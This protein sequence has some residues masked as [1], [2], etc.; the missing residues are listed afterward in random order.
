MTAI[1]RSGQ[2]AAGVLLALTAAGAAQAEP[3][4]GPSLN[5]ITVTATRVAEP[6]DQ[7][8]EPILVINRAEL[9]DSLAIDVG[10]V[11]RYHAGLD[12]GQTGG[13]GQ[14]LSL[15]IRGTN[16]DQS[17]VM[18]DGVRINAGT[19]ALAPLMNLSP[20]LFDRI[21]IVKG[22]RSAIYGT[23]AIGGVVNLLTRTGGVA[24]A[25]AMLDY[26]RYGT[27][28]FAVDGNYTVGGTSMQGALTGQQTS[29]FP[30]YAADTLD[31]GYKNLSGTAAITTHLGDFE[32]GARYFQATG[33]TDYANAV[34]NT[35]FTAFQSFTPLSEHFSNSLYALHASGDLTDFWHTLV[36][37]SR[38]VDDLRQEQDDPYALGSMGDFDYT[39]R[40]TIDLQNDVKITGARLNQTLTFGTIVYDEQTNSLIYGTGY[41][42]DTHAQTYYLQDQLE[43]GE[44][45]LL[46][47]T[48]VAH[49]PG[50]GD[51]TTW[52]AEYGY[53][54]TTD[55]LLTML[56]GTAFRAPSATDRFGFA[57]TPNLLPESSHNFEIGMK[58]RIASHQEI[59]FAA[60]QDTIDDLIVFVPNPLNIIYGGENQNVDRARIRGIEASWAL[61]ADLWSVLA[62]A[63]LQDP[64]N[65]ADN[66][67]LL[68]RTKH[69]FTLNGT[70]KIGRGEL[71][72]DLLLSGPRAD[73]DV[74][75]TAPVEDGRYL[76]TAIYGKLN[77]TPAWSLTARLDNALKRQYQL[78]NGYN[79]AGRAA[80]IATRYSFR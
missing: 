34:Y 54:I 68:R 14:P 16:S 1:F 26:G 56:A 12:I 74:V 48:G 62:E 60:F 46:L 8:L 17:I 64:V 38:V 3:D 5:E 4:S 32:F 66:S 57:G 13:A 63:S 37:L 15:F 79:T 59:T 49:Y 35:D 30:T 78:A 41:S 58:S 76:L 18:I 65:L 70:R 7:A 20:E 11:L 75:T 51:H 43:A 9:A 72:M 23:D 47:A 2:F 44:N 73:L 39:S 61:R 52:N 6:V 71:G 28:E 67:Q 27:G 77:L 19:Q 22:P 45:R 36:T 55:T 10:D 40:N 42:I 31:S 69:S 25:D 21:D 24:G 50:F 80:S 33:T 29:G 53:S